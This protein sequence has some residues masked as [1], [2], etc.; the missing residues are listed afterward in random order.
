MP[1]APQRGESTFWRSW[2]LW[3]PCGQ[4]HDLPRNYK[5]ESLQYGWN[6]RLEVFHAITAS[7]EHDHSKLYLGK[8]L[9]V[10][11][12]LVG[13]DQHMESEGCGSGE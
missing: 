12:V 3:G 10:L 5:R 13:R 4:P 2:S 6:Q 7:L 9:L 1:Q 8:V 11:H